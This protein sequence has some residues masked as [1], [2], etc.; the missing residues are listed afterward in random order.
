MCSAKISRQVV[1]DCA[2]FFG[3]YCLHETTKAVADRVNA[4]PHHHFHS[5]AY[6]S[7]FTYAAG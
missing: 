3:W 1:G 7:T 2:D 6:E 4:A 5:G